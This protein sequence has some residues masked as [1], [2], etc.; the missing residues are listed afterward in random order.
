MA[1]ETFLPNERQKSA[2]KA[3][4]LYVEKVTDDPLVFAFVEGAK[5]A[6]TNRESEQLMSG[7]YQV[8]IKTICEKY[9]VNEHDKKV[10]ADEI[11]E[12]EAK[13]NNKTNW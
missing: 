13:C 11:K 2:F 1:D 9:F 7:L 3:A 12:I 6:D 4:N 5:W 8:L 10:I